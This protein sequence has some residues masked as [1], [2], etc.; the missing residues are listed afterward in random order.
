MPG[1]GRSPSVVAKAGHGPDEPGHAEIDAQDPFPFETGPRRRG[2]YSSP[3]SFLKDSSASAGSWRTT[4]II[5]S[6]ASGGP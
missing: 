3:T 4:L 1:M 2:A 6:M 5:S